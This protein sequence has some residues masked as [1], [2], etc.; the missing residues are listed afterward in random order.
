MATSNTQDKAGVKMPLIIVAGVVLL[1]FLVFLGKT[2]LG[3]SHTAETEGMSKQD[4]L[5]AQ[6]AKQAG[7][8]A[9]LTKVSQDLAD[10]FNAMFGNAP[11]DHQQALKNWMSTHQGK[12]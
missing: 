2:F 10:K 11:I 4:Q 1:I 8:S 6:V 12:F 7:P 5:Y 3:P 9:D